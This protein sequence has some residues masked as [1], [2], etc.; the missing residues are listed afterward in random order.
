MSIVV[1]ELNI[2]AFLLACPSPSCLSC[3]CRLDDYHALCT[4]TLISLIEFAHRA[5]SDSNHRLIGV[6]GLALL[7]IFWLAC[8]VIFFNT[9]DWVSEWVKGMSLVFTWRGYVNIDTN[10]RMTFLDSDCLWLIFCNDC[11][12][13]LIFDFRDQAWPRWWLD[14]GIHRILSLVVWFLHCLY[15][16]GLR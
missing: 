12:I 10:H 2:V 7:V 16:L 11:Q 5:G 15:K 14:R 1:L 8:R 13:G 6:L 4:S 9:S 3:S